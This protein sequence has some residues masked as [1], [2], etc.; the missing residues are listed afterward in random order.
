MEKE[1]D[2][3]KGEGRRWSSASQGEMPRTDPSFTA[4]RRNQLY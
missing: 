4:L 1:D 3:M 2:E